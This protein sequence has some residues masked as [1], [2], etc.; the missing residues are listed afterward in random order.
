MKT[1]LVEFCL[2]K[3]ILLG[4]FPNPDSAEEGSNSFGFSFEVL[5]ACE[6]ASK[7]AV[8]AIKAA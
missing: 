6:V 2:D 5:V 7:A 3:L 4:L 8:A 1:Y